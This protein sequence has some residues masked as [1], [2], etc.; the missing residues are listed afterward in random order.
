MG[1][2][3]KAV[4]YALA[5]S[6]VLPIAAQAATDDDAIAITLTAAHDG[7]APGGELGLGVVQN[8]APGWH[9][10]W[11]NPGETG[12]PAEVTW[13]LPAGV[14]VEPIQWP[15][16]RRLEFSGMV[17]YGYEAPSTL[18]TRLHAANT[19]A[20][21]THLTIKAH[22]D[23][24]V[25]RDV[26]EPVSRDLSIIVPV[27]QS[28]PKGDRLAAA[29]AGLPKPLSF[30]V[31][32]TQRDGRAVF[33]FTALEGKPS[34]HLSDDQVRGA[35]F[36]NE[37]ADVMAPAAKQSI[38][39]LPTGFRVTVAAPR[40]TV[41]GPAMAGILTLG[42]GQSFRI[43]ASAVP[44]P[45][46]SAGLSW[47][48][49]A[50]AVGLAFLGGL[51]LNLMPCVFPILSMKLL[52]LTRTGRETS[53]ARTEALL[54]GVG[55]ML[56]FLSLAA[57]LEVAR[58]LGHSLGW[59]FQMQS[60]TVTAALSLILLLV[61]LNMSGLFEIGQGLQS[62][63]GN[64]AGRMARLSPSANA[65]LT[66][67]LAVVVAA[68]CTAPFMA[69]AVGVA[70]AQGG[71]VSLAIFTALGLGFAAPFVI[72]AHLLTR[73]PAVT[74]YLPKPGH[75]MS[76]LRHA[77]AVPMYTAAAWMV[78]VFAQ[79]VSPTGVWLLALALVSIGATLIFSR[80]SPWIK[81]AGMGL[82]VLAGVFG[83]LQAPAA[84][85][86]SA[87]L[88]TIPYESF[89][90]SRLTTLQA[91]G[92]PVL[93]DLTAAWCIT[94]KVNERSALSDGKVITALKASGTVYMVG[95]WTRQDSGI[96]AYLHTFGRSG[97]P[98]YVYYAPGR[99][100]VILP[101]V[102]NAGALVKTLAPNAVKGDA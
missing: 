15:T 63:A 74:K 100:P 52:A 46:R 19:L 8:P 83:A 55:V 56:S 92:R 59:G 50:L 10:Y 27:M 2:V 75:W 102:L 86:A 72:M 49:L 76:R 41:A 5:L 67:V 77:L 93:V 32:A 95:D 11:L 37:S 81:G 14:T 80:S 98:L 16:P 44:A 17:T 91:Q 65:F 62:V 35:Y 6:L 42:D 7:I 40:P 30:N 58:L 3:L 68:P 34:L 21:G 71:G 25:C 36:F 60:P 89:S 82:G 9:T 26:C 51:V 39:A 90:A 57:V 70:L 61:A 4:I 43:K 85:T 96:T 66:G 53:A 88:A 33:D 12:A 73:I 69:T 101:Q 54:Y 18:I 29:M 64:T 99:A 78:W 87:T 1:S 84:G 23:T 24:L 31:A 48:A 79:Q 97:V 28:A 94:C 13:Q 22:I 47:A 45:P 20:A 38:T